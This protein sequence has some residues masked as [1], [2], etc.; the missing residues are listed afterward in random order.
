MKS[1]KKSRTVEI[2]RLG[3]FSLTV[4]DTVCV[5]D[6]YFKLIII[7][8][9]APCEDMCHHVYYLFCDRNCRR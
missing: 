9:P 5:C 4:L 6:L 8:L 2:V 3:K 7:I 1:G